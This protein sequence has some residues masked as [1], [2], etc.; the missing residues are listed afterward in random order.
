MER[1]LKVHVVHNPEGLPAT[2][3]AD[4]DGNPLKIEGATWRFHLFCNASSNTAK[5]AL[6]LEEVPV[7]CQGSAEGQTFETQTKG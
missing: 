6:V 5:V 7:E 3:L 4:E 2:Y 1:I